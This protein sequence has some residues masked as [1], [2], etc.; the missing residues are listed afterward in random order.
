MTTSESAIQV[1]EPTNG[2]EGYKTV[3]VARSLVI[4]APKKPF[5]VLLTDMSNKPVHISTVMI[6]AHVVDSSMHSIPTEAALMGIDTEI[7]GVV[8][9]RPYADRNAQMT[10]RKKVEAK[11]VGKLKLVWK[12]EVKL[13]GENSECRDHFLNML[14]NYQSKWDV[15]LGHVSITKHRSRTT[16]ENTQSL[17]SALYGVGTDAREF[18]KSETDTRLLQ[19]FIKSAW[20][21]LAALTLFAPKKDG[22][23]WF[24]VN[25]W[26]PKPNARVKRRLHSILCMDKF[27]D[28]PDEALVCHTLSYNIGDW[29]VEV[30]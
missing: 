13:S 4:R 19:K 22:L 6:V 17:H 23:I 2:C 7:V 9:Y 30:K 11:D 29:E 12:S 1:L 5:H 15:H 20:T 18:E 25:Y 21:Q 24:S 26:K 8:P 10:S 3:Q 28:C 27:I 16:E 14:C